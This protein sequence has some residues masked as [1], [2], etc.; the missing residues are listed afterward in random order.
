MDVVRRTAHTFVINTLGQTH[1]LFY[2][3]TQIMRTIELII[4]CSFSFSESSV[5]FIMQSVT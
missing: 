2:L 3:T 5:R 4:F 1:A